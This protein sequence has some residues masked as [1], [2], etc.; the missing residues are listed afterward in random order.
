MAL[1]G[2]HSKRTGQ[3]CRARAM[4]NGRCNIHGGKSLIGI[5]SGTFQTGRWSKHVPTRLAARVAESEADPNLISLRSEI[6]LLDGRI[7]E[8]LEQVDNSEAGELWKRCKE[9]MREYDQAKSPESQY[10]AL[11]SLRF[12]INE[13]YKDYMS[14]MD[15]RHTIEDRRRLADSERQRLKDMQAMIDAKSVT[16]LI[17]QI[18]LII[19]DHVTDRDTLRKIAASIGALTPSDAQGCD[20]G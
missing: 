5:A 1:C 8:L 15:I 10:E 7:A 17:G 12:Y 19:R 3:P 9:A 13:G 6:A 11:G 20:T 18:G 4:P 14:W 16:V 2:A